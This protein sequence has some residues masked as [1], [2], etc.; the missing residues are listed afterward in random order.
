MIA[1]GRVGQ[2]HRYPYPI[3]C[4]ANAALEDRFDSQPLCDIADIRVFTFERERR[5]AG[6][7]L[8][9]PNM[10]KS[11]Q[12]LFRQAV[13]EIFVF[14]VRTYIYKWKNG[15]GSGYFA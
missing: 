6:G 7:D 10:R 5:S 8:Q 1:V 9:A 4:L 12:Q 13:A 14:G 3:S 2:L 15:Y 11:I